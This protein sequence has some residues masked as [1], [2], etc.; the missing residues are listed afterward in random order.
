[1]KNLTLLYEHTSEGPYRIGA[2]IHYFLGEFPRKLA[3]KSHRFPKTL[4]LLRPV[5]LRD[6]PVSLEDNDPVVP[7]CVGYF[8]RPGSQSS[9]PCR[10]RLQPTVT[11]IKMLR[12][13]QTI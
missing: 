2:D 7:T 12:K 8:E 5:F 10:I 9:V 4:K 11:K 6:S 1:M 13:R 3:L